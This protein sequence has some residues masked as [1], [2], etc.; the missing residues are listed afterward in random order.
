MILESAAAP[1][2][3]NESNVLSSNCVVVKEIARPASCFPVGLNAFPWQEIDH[4]L[5]AR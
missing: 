3:P 1:N 5:S 4:G 2:E